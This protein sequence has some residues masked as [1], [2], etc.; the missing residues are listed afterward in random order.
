[1]KMLAQ[2]QEHLKHF[3]KMKRLLRFRQGFFERADAI[4]KHKING[5]GLKILRKNN[6]LEVEITWS[7]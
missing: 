6:T 3:S 2:F 1:M 4:N 7:G 5:R